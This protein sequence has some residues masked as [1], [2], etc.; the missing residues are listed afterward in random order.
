ML[1]KKL[2]FVNRTLKMKL[3]QMTTDT[4]EKQQEIERVD[5][6]LEVSFLRGLGDLLLDLLLFVYIH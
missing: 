2:M 4:K 5:M 3:E 6:K 1:K